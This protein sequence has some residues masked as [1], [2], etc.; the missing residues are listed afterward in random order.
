MYNSFSPKQL[1]VLSWWCDSS[2]Y[3]ECN[4]IICDGA[5]RSG[6][7]VC[8]SLSFVLWAFYRFDNASFAICSKTIRSVR[9]NVISP[10]IANMIELGFSAKERY[11]ENY[12]EF[13]K[14]SH[15]NRFYF[16][17]GKDEGSA[18]LIQGM[19]LSGIMLDE[20]ALMPRSFVEQALA[21]CSVDGS[22]FWFNCNPEYPQHWFRQEWILKQK[23]KKVLYIHFTMDDNPSLSKEVVQRYKSLYSGAFYR[24]FV[25]GKWVAS[26]GAVY[27]FMQSESAFYPVPEG[28]AERYIISCDYGTVNPSSFGLWGLFEGVW[29][30]IDEYYY[31]SRAEG[32]QRTDEEHYEGLRKLSGGKNIEMIIVDPS[33][34]SFI[35]TIRRHCEFN[36][37]PADNK[38][39]DGIRC[40][41]SA[42]HSGCVRICKTCRAAMREFNLYRWDESGAKDCPIKE[43]DHAMDDIR[44]FVTKVVMTGDEGI[45][46]ISVTR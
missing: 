21:R 24:R 22:K 8:M 36:V 4:S 26:A 30:R 46:A 17:G 1:K 32:F 14:G 29:Y 23:E 44:Y 13:Y 11:S 45:F 33:A 3:K 34:A 25:E 10:L 28:E 35:Q 5:V 27:P 2:L 20:V 18:A 15:R 16:F 7:T 38:V 12:V 31:D 37:V 6:K 9:R 19:T 39:L 42:L 40:V 41:S 43:N